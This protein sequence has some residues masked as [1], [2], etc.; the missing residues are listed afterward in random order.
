MFLTIRDCQAVIAMIRIEDDCCGCD[1]PAYPCIGDSCPLRH[2]KHFYCDE[3]GEESD[4]LYRFE[5]KELCGECIL[6]RLEI[7]E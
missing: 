5:S 6:K 3:C 2:Q 7:V 4:T 1:V